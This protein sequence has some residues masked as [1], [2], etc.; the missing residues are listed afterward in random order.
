MYRQNVRIRSFHSP[1]LFIFFW[2]SS[3][4]LEHNKGCLLSMI[5]D[6]L[7]NQGF[8]FPHNS[9]TSCS[10]SPGLCFPRVKAKLLVL[11]FNPDTALPIPFP[12]LDCLYLL[13]CHLH[14]HHHSTRGTR[15]VHKS[16]SLLHKHLLCLFF[17]AISLD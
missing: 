6:T 8:F 2:F 4:K 9:K 13:L 5:L 15:H 12:R 7:M 3:G 1:F 16:N 14:S 10:A 11:I 17:N